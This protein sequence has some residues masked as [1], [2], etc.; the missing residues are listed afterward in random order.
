MP[1]VKLGTITDRKLA[2]I[3]YV[4]HTTKALGGITSYNFNSKNG[5]IVSV[6]IYAGDCNKEATTIL[7]ALQEE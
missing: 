4:M 7:R 3:P 5:K 1:I 6:D 2:R